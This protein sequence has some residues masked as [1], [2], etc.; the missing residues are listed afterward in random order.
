MLN[1]IYHEGKIYPQLQAT[2]NAA[3]F[4]LPFAKEMLHGRGVDVGCCKKEWA[5]PDAIP[6]DLDFD[7]EYHATNLPT[8]Q[9]D[10]IFSSH[11]L[12]HLDDWVGVMDYWTDKLVSGGVMFLYLPHYSQ[13]YWRPWNNRKHVN[14]LSPELLLDYYHSRPYDKL[15]VTEGWDLNNSFYAIAQKR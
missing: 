1:T 2:G 7:D 5:F 13:T 12:E 11:C 10:Y 9:F 6:I 14:V 15:L 3:R 8:G 4:A